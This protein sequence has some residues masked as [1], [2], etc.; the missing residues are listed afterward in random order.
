MTGGPI[1]IINAPSETNVRVP[2]LLL[3]DLRILL[4]EDEPLIAIDV[5]QLCTDH[6]ARSVTIV[7]HLAQ[8][9][10]GEVRN[11]FDAAI[12]DLMLGG[13]STLGF[14][15]RLLE[16][17]LPFIIASGRSAQEMEALL[18]GIAIVEKPYSGMDLVEALAAACARPPRVRQ[19]T[20]P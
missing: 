6:G 19:P 7:Q 5:E 12:I 8:I 14:A 18:P 17:D 16:Q 11:L 4:L 9:D 3:D 20:S 2:V 1:T 13:Q 15:Q 10:A